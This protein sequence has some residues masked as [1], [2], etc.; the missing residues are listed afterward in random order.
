MLMKRIH[1]LTLLLILL[2]IHPDVYSQDWS[3]ITPS[4][5]EIPPGRRNAD[6]VYDAQGH[7]MIV[8]GGETSAGRV[9]DIWAFD[10][11]SNSWENLTPLSGVSPA[12]RRTPN[13]I[14]DNAN[15]Q[16]IMWS[17]LG[18]AFYN[19]IWRF[20]ISDNEWTA[21]DPAGP[22][23]EIRYG[24]VSV[25]D[26]AAGHLVTFGGFTDQGRFQD[27]WAFDINNPQWNEITPSQ[28]SPGERCLHTAVYDTLHH[29]M[30]MYGGL[31]NAGRLSDIW[32]LDL[33]QHTWEELTPASTPPGRYFTVAVYD[34]GNHRVLIFSGN[35]DGASSTNDLWA[36]DLNTNI[37]EELI[38][39]GSLPP[40]RSGASGIYVPG[41]N[42]M[43]VFGG[44]DGGYL[45]DLWSLNNLSPP[46]AISELD[47]QHLPAQITLAQNYPNP[48]NPATNI[49]FQISASRFV[50]LDVYD[51]SGR[52][53]KTLVREN[54]SPGNYT[55][56][57]DGTNQFGQQVGSGVYF[58]R[59][60]SAGY[61]I[62]QKMLL[63]R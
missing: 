46:T 31:N 12:P 33:T 28:G 4:T 35:A 2:F 63:T 7:R 3:E 21:Y 45:N 17:G 34:A 52:L 24:A 59:I 36:F 41:E 27:T 18:T 44:R 56:R 30:I 19:D 51:V 8:F 5:G 11:A 22:L 57:W 29:R 60:E 53:V 9:N 14:Y 54:R 49:E 26:P 6:A 10:F 20:D 16:V 38:L 37:W 58:Y 23:P 61:T 55:E 47:E 15:H 50:T 42:R 1:Y 32:A 13:M 40:I 48:F 43:V 25:L 39:T 62:T